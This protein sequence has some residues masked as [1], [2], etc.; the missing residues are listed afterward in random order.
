MFIAFSA[1]K[2]SFILGVLGSIV[3]KIN[4]RYLGH[5]SSSPSHPDSAD[6]QRRPSGLLFD[7]SRLGPKFGD[8]LKAWREKQDKIEEIPILLITAPDFHPQSYI[9]ANL[10]S[11]LQGLELLHREFFDAHRF[12]DDNTRKS[13]IN[14]LRE[15]IPSDL[16]E[17]L[18][19]ALSQGLGFIGG[20]TLFDRIQQLYSFYPKKSYSSISQGHRRSEVA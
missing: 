13:T 14:A 20:L 17:E 3:R 6:L 1:R 10:L 5:F 8:Y 9:H 2:A 7:Q 15:A 12:P 11:Y 16:N 19:D 4:P 18:K